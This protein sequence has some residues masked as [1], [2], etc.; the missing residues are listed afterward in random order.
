MRYDIA[1]D[2]DISGLCQHGLSHMGEEYALC[3]ESLVIGVDGGVI[4][5]DGKTYI[6]LKAL[7]DKEVCAARNRAEHLDPTGVASKREHLPLELESQGVRRRSGRV[8]HLER[9]DGDAADLERL[10]LLIFDE[11]QLE[12]PLC[13]DDVRIERLRGDGEARR[14][15][16]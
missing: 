7:R 2:V 9:R 5:V 11:A 1:R 10:L 6:V 13:R 14:N 8:L 12:A 16:P 3:T 15:A 4:E